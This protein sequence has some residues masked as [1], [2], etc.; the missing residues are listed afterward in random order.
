MELVEMTESGQITIPLSLRERLGLKG[1][2]KVALVGEGKGVRLL[3]PFAAALRE[4]REA[5]LGEAE[6]AGLADDEA[7]IDYCREVREE[8]VRERHAHN[9]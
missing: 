2:D 6:K 3:H 4:V 8:S 1:G 9:A 5:M 7:I